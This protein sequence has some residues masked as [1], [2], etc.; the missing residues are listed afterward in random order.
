ML[1][2][3]AERLGVAD[4]PSPGP[5]PSSSKVLG[6]HRGRV[7]RAGVA[8]NIGR[9][10][11]TFMGFAVGVAVE[12]PAACA[13]M[14]AAARCRCAR[15][16]LRAGAW[17]PACCAGSLGAGAPPLPN[18]GAR[19][20]QHDVERELE[21]E[22]VVAARAEKA[23]TAGGAGSGCDGGVLRVSARAF[24]W[25]LAHRAAPPPVVGSPGRVPERASQTR[26]GHVGEVNR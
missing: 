23:T 4:E 14:L 18:G 9:S 6:E 7:L 1:R 5:D 25:L 17:L 22:L 12:T 20:H 26:A 3:V 16:A 19:D 10:N 8:V 24:Q 21:L 13:D 15:A 2:A 11:L